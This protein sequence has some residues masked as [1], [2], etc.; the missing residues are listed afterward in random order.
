MSWNS[1]SPWKKWRKQLQDVN[2]AVNRY[3]Y[4]QILSSIGKNLKSPPCVFE[5]LKVNDVDGW[6]LLD[7][8]NDMEQFM[9]SKLISEQNRKKILSKIS[10][11]PIKKFLFGYDLIITKKYKYHWHGW[12]QKKNKKLNKVNIFILH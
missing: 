2:P 6:M 9:K 3:R 1:N 7:D 5:Y 10:N 11:N 12:K 8:N 4:E